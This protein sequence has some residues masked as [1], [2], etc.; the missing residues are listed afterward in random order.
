MTMRQT[1][2]ERM[3][4]DHEAGTVTIDG[5]EFGWH[6][7]VDGPVVEHLDPDFPELAT[8]HLPVLVL[9]EVVEIHTFEQD[10]DWIRAEGARQLAEAQ[11][12]YAGQ[13]GEEGRII[14]AAVPPFTSLAKIVVNALARAARSRKSDFTLAA[15]R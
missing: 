12:W 2:A 9:G 6:V 1:L 4:I 15:P 10:L 14:R 13:H 5:E 7:A 11:R 8:V 3:V